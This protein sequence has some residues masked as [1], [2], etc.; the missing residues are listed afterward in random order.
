MTSCAS[1][2]VVTGPSTYA[3]VPLDDLRAHVAQPLT[4]DDGQL[5]AI[6]EA[7]YEWVEAYLGRRVLSTTLRAWYDGFD[8]PALVLPEPVTAVTSV[9]TYTTA[10]VS[11]VV[12]ASTYQ[13]NIHR[14]PPRLVLR[15]GQVW[16][17]SL[18]DT[19]A[20]AVVYTAGWA[21]VYAVPANIKHALRMLVAHW[22][23]HRQPVQMGGHWQS[24]PMGVEAL[25][26]PHRV[27]SGA[28]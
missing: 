27:R 6:A 11:S 17:T 15:S 19:A 3:V 24:V 23:E 1:V 4:D 28:R 10:D 9:T 16:P 5:Q 22:Y 2:E 7:A 26:M 21:D 20:V 13:V 14:L 8:G 25:L 12:D 18:R